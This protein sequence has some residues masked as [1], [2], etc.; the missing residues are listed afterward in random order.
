ML[1]IC[2]HTSFIARESGCVLRFPFKFCAGNWR[3]A[4]II[5]RMHAMP[6]IIKGD[7]RI[8]SFPL[9]FDSIHQ[10]S[11]FISCLFQDLKTDCTSKF[12]IKIIFWVIP[13]K[14][15]TITFTQITDNTWLNEMYNTVNCRLYTLGL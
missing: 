5:D 1:M 13:L 7:Y 9:T 12:I 6:A 8:I 4:K 10:P 3:A 15:F 11:A 14:A 2:I